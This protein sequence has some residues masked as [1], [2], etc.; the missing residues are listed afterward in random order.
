[1]AEGQIADGERAT[2]TL[3]IKNR[4]GDIGTDLDR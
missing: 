4:V 1:M 2:G 3:G